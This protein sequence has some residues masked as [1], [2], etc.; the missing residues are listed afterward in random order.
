MIF[1]KAVIMAGG[2]GSRL[3]PLTCN[4]PKPLAPLLG[5]PV[6]EY[7]LD[8]LNKHNF[9][10]ATLTLMY[11]GN[12]IVEH[13][14]NGDYKDI[15]LSFA[16]EEKP[17]GT[18][19]SVK[20]AVPKSEEA[21]LIISG[22]AMCDF[23][24]TKAMDFHIKN[25]SDA[26]LIV[27]KVSDPREYGLVNI[28]SE[29]KIV[30]FLEKPSLAHCI[31]DLANTGIYILSP[32]VLEL[33]KDNQIVDFSNDIFPLMLEKGYNL[34][35]Y[36]DKGY[37]CDI[38]DFNSYIKCQQDMLFGKVDFEFKGTKY[39]DLFIKDELPT[40]QGEIEANCYIGKNVVIGE[41]TKILSGTIIGDNVTIG[42]NCKINQ[43]VMLDGCFLG[44]NV[45][46]NHSIICNNVKIMKN[47]NVFEDS[48]LGDNVIIN[49]DCN[50]SLG[51]KIWTNKIIPS[52]SN[53]TK[54]VKY[55]N[56][57]NIFCDEDGICGLTNVDITP[58]LCCKIGAAIGSLKSNGVIGVAG[59]FSNISQCLKFAIMS[60]ILS[61]GAKAWDFGKCIESQFNFCITK[62]EVDYGIF[63]QGGTFSNIKLVEKGAMPLLRS[64]ERSIESS[65]N[66]N[67]FKK[68]KSSEFSKI[69]DVSSLNEMYI[70]E[71]FKS[72]KCSLEGL[73]VE[74]E[75]NNLQV[76]NT[77]ER[78][79]YNLGCKKGNDI[80]LKFNSQ[81]TE[82]SAYTDETGY[83]FMEKIITLISVDYF[84]NGQDI[85][86]SFKAPKT[87]DILAERYK[88]K[89][90]RY[91]ENP[92]GDK[93]KKAR[94]KAIC[95]PTFR[96]AL[97]LGIKLLCF[98]NHNKISLERG[99][100]LIPE[101]SLANRFVAVDNN[102]SAIIKSLNKNTKEIT[103]GVFIEN[104][105]GSILIKPIKSGKGIMVYSESVNSE[106]SNELCDFF[107]DIIKNTSLDSF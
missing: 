55:G 92:C 41:N 85:A 8:L 50:I 65:L 21:F 15:N 72:A 56:Y 80:K 31:T 22:D 102:P 7:I 81:G 36:E 76:K 87:I 91:F 61:S 59:D 64:T 66:R 12:K 68:A 88:R 5:R 4:I 11:Q 40:I 71:L 75:C 70:L 25:N 84:L 78:V 42:D 79:I 23:D 27:K 10:D 24:L 105:K 16:F 39:K 54:D 98:L 38:G 103:E 106:T 52:H 101:F 3:N 48:V 93:D 20:N 33:I 89:V 43:S 44:D 19:G 86:V 32:K 34:F 14:D 57:N 30:G 97:M 107:E 73:G 47:S 69:T 45:K 96:D 99:L 17:L 49:Q 104:E 37:W 51:A 18:A 29:N 74:V 63:I 1:L 83:V 13:F 82:L 53:I 58:E 77:F 67:D 100:K 6:L 9:N 90:Y 46:C 95:Q 62:S 28:N 2:K 94:E 60:G 35:A 26:T